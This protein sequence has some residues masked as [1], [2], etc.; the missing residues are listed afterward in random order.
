MERLVITNIATFKSIADEAYQEMIQL[1]EAGRRPKPDGSPGWIKTYDPNQKS[2]K[3]AMV[4]I[5]FTGMWLDAL[6]HLLIVEKYGMDKAK[7]YRF[8]KYEAKLTFLELKNKELID[9]VA[10]F[11]DCRNSLAHENAHFDE[12]DIKRAQDE[13]ENAHNML[14]AIYD[15][16]L[17]K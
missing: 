7:E 13:A 10:R 5:I 6:T 4:S 2:F 17:E 8:K 3:Q 11:R 1:M 12:G 9:S 16:F 14:V 15:Y